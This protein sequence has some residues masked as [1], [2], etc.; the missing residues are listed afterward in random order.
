LTDHAE[1]QQAVLDAVEQALAAARARVTEQHEQFAF[2]GSGA[3]EDRITIDV[4]SELSCPG[5]Y[6]R[7]STMCTNTKDSFTASLHVVE[8]YVTL[9]SGG[10]AFSIGL[11][12]QSA[13]RSS[14]A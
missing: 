2:A 5:P 4:A 9:S 12:T 13:R 10:L 14:S 3:D 7:H 1:K 11:T 6:R 8:L